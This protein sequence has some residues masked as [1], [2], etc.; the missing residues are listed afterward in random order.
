MCGRQTAQWHQHRYLVSRDLDRVLAEGLDV[1]KG[2]IADDGGDRRNR[3]TLEEVADGKGDGP[4]RLTV[5][6]VDDIGPDRGVA[7]GRGGLENSSPAAG[8]VEDQRAGRSEVLFLEQP[9]VA[10]VRLDVMALRLAVPDMGAERSRAKVSDAGHDRT[11]TRLRKSGIDEFVGI[12][13]SAGVV[14]TSAAAAGVAV[15]GCRQ[16]PLAMRRSAKWRAAAVMTAPP[17]TNEACGKGQSTR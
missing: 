15:D 12:A 2:R 11:T 17:R 4:N 5:E 3:R 8:R 7:G 13:K 1:I 16:A 9:L 6:A 10:P 14:A